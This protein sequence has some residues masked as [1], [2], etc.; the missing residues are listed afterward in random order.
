[1]VKRRIKNRKAKG[2]AYADQQIHP[3]DRKD[4]G[5]VARE[6]P[7]RPGAAGLARFVLTG[8]PRDV[9]ALRDHRLVT[10]RQI[11]GGRWR[12]AERTAVVVDEWRTVLRPGMHLC[13]EIGHVTRPLPDTENTDGEAPSEGAAVL[14]PFAIAGLTAA[15]DSR[16]AAG[17]FLQELLRAFDG[18]IWLAPLSGDPST[19]PASGITL[20]PR[21][22]IDLTPEQSARDALRKVL[23]TTG[24]RLLEIAPMAAATRAPIA[25]HQLRVALR[26]FRANESAFRKAADGA[27]HPLGARARDL[28]QAVSP[29]RDW[30]VFLNDQEMREV[31]TA[32]SSKGAAALYE[33]ADAL[34]AEAWRVASHMAAG[35][36]LSLFA[37]DLMMAAEDDRVLSSDGLA[38]PVARV[39][40]KLLDK[41]LKAA[42]RTATLL[43]PDDLETAHALRLDIKKLRYATQTFRTLYPK[44]ARKAYM[45]AMADLQDTFGKLNDAVVA[46]RLAAMAAR[47]RGEAAARTAGFLAGLRA[48]QARCACLTIT[49]EWRAFAEETPFWR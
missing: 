29:A 24:D 42:S 31:L 40:H 46:G 9:M 44:E 13:L 43:H 19:F 8:A 21:T 33:G 26:R 39:A 12:R 1:M 36:T 32:Y 38:S 22:K 47:G 5:G 6:E 18:R 23:T 3:K 17:A 4:D 20:A 35:P 48:E 34:R 11:G 28:A 27:L 45:T 15:G 49:Q 2:V 25:L 16:L 10:A 7:V 37:L 41:K 14:A 30:D